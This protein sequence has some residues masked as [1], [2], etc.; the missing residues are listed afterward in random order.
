MFA[1]WTHTS[2]AW[3]IENAFPR[4]AKIG[5]N[6]MQIFAKSPRWWK[7][8]EYDDSQFQQWMIWRKELDQ[9]RGLVHSNYLAN[10][11]KPTDETSIE[12][13]SI[14][15]DFKVA[16]KLWCEAVNVHVGK[17]KWRESLDEAMSNMVKNV[18]C[19]L[20]HVDD[21][22]WWEVQYLFENTAWQWSEI[23]STL[24]E[25]WYFYKEYLQDLPV[26][27]TIDTAHC[28]WWWIDISNRENFL[29]EFDEKVWID[30]LHSIHLNDSK[31]VLWSKLDRH[32]SLGRGFIGMPAIANIVSWAAKNDRAV[33]I[34]TPEPELWPDE[35]EMVKKI[36]DDNT[37]W[38]DWFN[39]TYYKTQYLKKFEADAKWTWLFW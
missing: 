25:L 37:D 17:M 22:G 36:V 7:I 10:L 39:S 30:Q 26:K 12:I 2:I 27:F 3:W 14:V 33:Y 4:S 21:N 28:R 5:W 11:A 18:E 9:V 19:I 32:A 1:V 8:P 23:G 31:V 38:I 13:D 16:Y 35:I 29:S 15:H 20:K 34:E 24:D 6:T